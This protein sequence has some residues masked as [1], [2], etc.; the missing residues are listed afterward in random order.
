LQHEAKTRLPAEQAAPVQPN[1]DV[2]TGLSAED[3]ELLALAEAPLTQ[4]DE[5]L[6][7]AVPVQAPGGRG[8]QALSAED[9]QLLA[10]ADE[11]LL[12]SSPLPAGGATLAG[13]SSAMSGSAAGVLS[14]EQ[15]KV[16]PPRAEEQSCR[17]EQA[18][19]AG[20]PGSSMQQ[21]SPCAEGEMLAEGPESN[22]N[23]ASS[24]VATPADSSSG[25]QQGLDAAELLALAGAE[26]PQEAGNGKVQPGPVVAASSMA[27]GACPVPVEQCASA[28]TA[29]ASGLT[30]AVGGAGAEQH[31]GA[32]STVNG[33]GQHDSQV[34]NA[35]LQSEA[36]QGSGMD[37]DDAELLALL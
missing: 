21:P 4:A 22:L 10:L 37:E 36:G 2:H 17:A 28:G 3:E 6:E 18:A 33:K 7:E 5:L 16:P 11:P 27:I 20:C 14:T 30:E 12:D 1:G 29:A 25:Q 35:G 8:P 32:C 23:G 24:L 15:E 26:Q 13:R 34:S 31:A 9:E 19:A